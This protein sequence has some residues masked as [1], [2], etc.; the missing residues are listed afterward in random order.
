MACI[1]IAPFTG[2][3]DALH[4][5]VRTKQKRKEITQNRIVIRSMVDN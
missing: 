2:P 1:Y 3:K 4:M 5:S